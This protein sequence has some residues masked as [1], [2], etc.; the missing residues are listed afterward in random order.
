[1]RRFF[2]GEGHTARLMAYEPSDGSPAHM[3]AWGPE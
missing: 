2:G 1:M 3:T